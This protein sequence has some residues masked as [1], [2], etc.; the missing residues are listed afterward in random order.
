MGTN[1]TAARGCFLSRPPS[2]IQ[3]YRQTQLPGT[4]GLSYLFYVG[5]R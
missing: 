5:H 1:Q 2:E 4:A 3:G